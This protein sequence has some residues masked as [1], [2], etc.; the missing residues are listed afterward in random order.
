MM[1]SVKLSDD[2]LLKDAFNRCERVFKKTCYRKQSRTSRESDISGFAGQMMRQHKSGCYSGFVV[3][4]TESAPEPLKFWRYWT[5]AI[6]GRSGKKT[7]C[8]CAPSLPDN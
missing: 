4:T 7:Q 5:V 1:A 6:S 2:A 3:N 8:A